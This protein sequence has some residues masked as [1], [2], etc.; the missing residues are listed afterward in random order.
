VWGQFP[1]RKVEEVVQTD[2]NNFLVEP[3]DSSSFMAGLTWMDT[4]EALTPTE[5]ETAKPTSK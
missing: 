1:E 2:D 3:T 4:I 5:Y